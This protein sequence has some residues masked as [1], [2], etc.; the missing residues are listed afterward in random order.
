MRG[1]ML[2]L[3][4]TLL[5]ALGWIVSKIVV[6]AMPGNLF[7]VSRFLLAGLMLLPFCL[8]D[9][10]KLS[11]SRIAKVIGVGLLMSLAMLVWIHAVEITNTLAEGAFIVSLA[12]VTAPMVAWLLF[13]TKPHRAFWVALPISVFGLMLMTLESGWNFEESQLFFLLSSSLLSFHFVIQLNGQHKVN[14]EVAALIMILL[15]PVWTLV[16]SMTMLGETME[17]QKLLGGAVIILSLITYTKLSIKQS[18]KR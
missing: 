15:E 18:L 4:T 3:I 12:M 6:A 13:R 2:L 8:N 14:V 17:V 11:N 9:I 5:A 16:L 1:E 7:I 10:R